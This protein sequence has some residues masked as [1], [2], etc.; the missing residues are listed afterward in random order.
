[1]MRWFWTTQQKICKPHWIPSE[2]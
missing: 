1:M 2:H